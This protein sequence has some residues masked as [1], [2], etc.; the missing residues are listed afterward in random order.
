V[1]A[2][3]LLVG[4]EGALAAEVSGLGIGL[5]AGGAKGSPSVLCWN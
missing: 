5:E 3:V 2:S 1:V 4:A